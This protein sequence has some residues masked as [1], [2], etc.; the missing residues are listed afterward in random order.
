MS[1]VHH[2]WIPYF[3]RWHKAYHRQFL[4]AGRERLVRKLR[5]KLLV[6]KKEAEFQKQSADTW[7]RQWSER[8][9]ELGREYDRGAEAGEQAG[10]DRGWADSKK[11]AEMALAVLM[12]Y[13]RRALLEVDPKVDAAIRKDL[14][15]EGFTL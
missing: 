1:E 3:G 5:R 9:A 8:V 6:A 4:A 14:E 10:Y 7:H 13:L 2:H 15:R 11:E 12:T